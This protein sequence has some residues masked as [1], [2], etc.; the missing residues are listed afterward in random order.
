MAAAGD[1][2][3]PIEIT[4][5]GVASGGPMPSPMIKTPGGQ[6]EFLRRAFRF[7]V[8]HRRGWRLSGADWFTWRDSVSEDPHCVFCRHAGLFDLADRPKPAWAAYR[9]V[10]A[11][12]G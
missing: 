6:A 5:F 4:E 7:L 10:A 8:D 3:K 1:R 9:A 12:P 2:R 11:D